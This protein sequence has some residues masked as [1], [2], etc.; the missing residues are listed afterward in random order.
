MKAADPLCVLL[1]LLFPTLAGMGFPDLWCLMPMP[2]DTG[3]CS[4]ASRT[5]HYKSSDSHSLFP[6]VGLHCA[7]REGRSHHH[8]LPSIF[9]RRAMQPQALQDRNVT[10]IQSVEV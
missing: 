2:G 10:V 1:P 7:F 8:D 6:D 5:S 9:L 4:A 3:R